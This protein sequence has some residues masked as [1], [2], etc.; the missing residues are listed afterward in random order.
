MKQKIK[1]IVLLLFCLFLISG[2][3]NTNNDDQSIEDETE[4][5]EGSTLNFTT[6]SISL[7]KMVKA[8]NI[9][10]L[11]KCITIDEEDV[12]DNISYQK[13]LFIF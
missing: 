8:D 6:D 10:K 3:K 1:V 4:S 13:M 12:V 11:D 7:Y 5:I 2:C 9:Y